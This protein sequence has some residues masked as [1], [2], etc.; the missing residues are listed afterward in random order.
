MTELS[1]AESLRK[2]RD[3]K[4]DRGL[5]YFTQ[6]WFTWNSNHMEGSTLT[7]DQTAQVFETGAF[8]PE[9]DTQIRVDDAIETTNHF[10]A[11]DFIL[12]HVDEPATHEMLW[13]LH[14]I[15][16]RGTRQE[17]DAKWNVGGYKT[18]NN[19]IGAF[20]PVATLPPKAEEKWVGKILAAYHDLTDSPYSIAALHWMFE[21]AHPFS[22]GNG[23]IGRLLMFKEL[24][25]IG[26]VPT[27]IR[28]E[29]RNYYIRGLQKFTEEPGYLVDYLLSERDWYRDKLLKSL[30]PGAV[31]H[32]EDQWDRKADT[33]VSGLIAELRS[34]LRDAESGLDA[35]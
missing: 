10:R 13:K 1:I 18:Q 34:V 17:T 24:L 19:V 31:W 2:E 29:K 3:E 22:D 16:K 15:L 32:Y 11:I 6:V 14:A 25:R 9:D 27:M 33:L 5:Y 21:S 30:A 20:L 26:T 12:D 7:P 35:A 8:L 23:R 4:V 28:D